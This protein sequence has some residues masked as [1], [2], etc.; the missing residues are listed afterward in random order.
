M[1]DPSSRAPAIDPTDPAQIAKRTE[2]AW[3]TIADA[4][5]DPATVQMIAVTKGFG[6]EVAEAAV[7]AGHLDLGEN[8]AQELIAKAPRLAARAPRWHFVGR[9]QTN[10]VRTLSDVVA[11]WQSVDRLKLGREIAARAPGARVLVQVNVTDEARKGGC[12]TAAAPELVAA[13]RDYGLDVR[14]LMTVGRTG[15]AREAVAGFETLVRLADQ[16][17]LPERSMGMSGDLSQ[18]VTAGSTMV[19]L[20]TTLF[21]PRPPR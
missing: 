3:N 7:A 13:L 5:G 1:T 6:P 18:A 20:G 2:Q 11:L 4:G 15:E 21:G 14:G 17:D 8:Y 12:A 19:R 16:L 9:L 10:K